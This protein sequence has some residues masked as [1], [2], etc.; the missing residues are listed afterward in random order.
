MLVRVSLISIL[1]IFLFF[2]GCSKLTEPGSGG[3]TVSGKTYLLGSAD[4]ISGVVVNCA[5]LST[6]SRGDGSY[7]LHGVPAGKQLITAEMVN[8]DRYSDTI[9]VKSDMKRYIY[10][11][12]RTT[13][14][15]GYVTNA[16][17]GP[18]AGA[19]V[20]M[21]GNGV[22]TDASGR[23][24]LP[25]VTG[26][27]DTLFVTHALYMPFKM[28]VPLDSSVKRLDVSLTR[29][30]VIQV[31]VTEDAYVDES[32]PDANFGASSTLLLS[33]NPSGQSGYQKHIYLKVDL[34]EILR[35]EDVRILDASLQL[36]MSSPTPAISVQTYS[37]AASWTAASITYNTQPARGALLG[38]ETIGNG[39]MGR[40]WS[41]LTTSGISQLIADWRA[42]RP[43]YGVVVQ[44]GPSGATPASF[45]SSEL[46][47]GA[48]KLTIQV[49]Y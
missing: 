39:F 26:A 49:Q 31:K 23:Y 42:N 15:W 17:D 25:P 38:T 36:M 14:L 19:A 47:G 30:R 8:C 21:Q 16:V 9:D 40:Y 11:T 28:V 20:R 46:S 41:I 24:E 18:I 7:E 4:P 29:Q 12:L 3:W 44:G 35:N 34:P 22:N 37:V 5:G 2:A 10:L 33:T 43:M 6:T 32:R 27:S 48:P 1:C 13:R 45:Y